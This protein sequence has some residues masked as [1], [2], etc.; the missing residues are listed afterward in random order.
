MKKHILLILAFAASASALFAA[1]DGYNAVRLRNVGEAGGTPALNAPARYYETAWALVAKPQNAGRAKAAAKALLAAKPAELESLCAAGGAK[2]AAKLIKISG[3]TPKAIDAAF[4]AR[5]GKYEAL[6]YELP[7]K[8]RLRPG[9]NALVFEEKGGKLLF[10]PSFADPF[11]S[12][13]ALSDF[14]NPQ[15]AEEIPCKTFDGADAE[16]CAAAAREKLPFLQFANGALV[17]EKPVEGVDAGSAAK[18][19][20]AAQDVFYSWKLDDYSAFMT[21]ESRAKFESQFKSMPDAERKK[22]LGEY[23]QWKKKYHKT[24]EAGSET[25]ILFSRHKPRR[26]PYDDTAYLA[27]A[28]GK[29]AITKFGAEKSALDLFLAKYVYPEEGYLKLISK[30]YGK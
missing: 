4:E 24:L 3:L 19:Y 8:T 26:E 5:I 13:L 17:S 7:A 18:F 27:A 22:V 23:F 2:R 21:P 29:F 10:N 1:P 28:G 20:R 30:K 9:M 14:K 25:L 16:I 6:V 11:I 12:L 15:S